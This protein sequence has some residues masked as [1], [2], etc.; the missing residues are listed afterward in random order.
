MLNY[1][2]SIG[3]NNHNMVAS[4]PCYDQCDQNMSVFYIYNG[5]ILSII[6]L[7]GKHI[8]FQNF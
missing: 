4:E 3:F 8:T 6:F 2:K 1:K 7:D 5:F